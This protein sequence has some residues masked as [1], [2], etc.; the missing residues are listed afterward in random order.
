MSDSQLVGREPCPECGSKDNL[1]R[2]DDGHGFC[3]GQGCGYYD[4]GDS[5]G[6]ACAPQKTRVPMIDVD[7][8]ALPHRGI[9]EDTCR[10]FKYGIGEYRGQPVQVAQYAGAQ[11]LRGANKA[12]SWV[13]T[14]EGQLYG[15]SLWAPQKRLV[16]TEGEIDCLSYA[17]A[18]DSRW[19]VVSVPNGAGGAKRAIEKNVEFCESFDEV[20]FLFDMDKPGQAAAEECAA[21]LSP[22]KARIGILS[23]KDP[24]EVLLSTGGVKELYEVPFKAKPFR[25]E[26]IV[27]GTELLEAI[28]VKPEQGISY[29]WSCLDR[30]TYGQRMDEVV[31]WIAG[32][33][34]GKSQVLR[35]VAMN[36]WSAHGERVG[37]ISLEEANRTSAEGFVSLEMNKR[38]HLP[39][40]RSKVS[41]EEIAAAGGILEGFAFYDHFGS[42]AGEILLPKIRY[43]AVALGIRWFVLDHLSIMISGTAT[44]GD[45]RKRLDQLCTQLRSLASELNIGLHVVSHLRKA[46]G[47]PHE[48]GG[49][50]S[51][52]DIRSSGA[53]AQISN[54]VIALERDQQAKGREQNQTTIRVLKNRFSGDLGI[55]GVLEFN[56]ETGRMSE[57]T[58]SP[59]TADG[60]ND[61]V[62]Y[63]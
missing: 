2:F 16:I 42:V 18:T 58:W 21:I 30:L 41:D 6:T 7:Y 63:F 49:K 31:T 57:T 45:E 35:E 54:I 38:L 51:L 37:V 3:F 40:V 5:E 59:E 14:S 15:Q 13:G 55:A 27:E 53:V 9:S 26:G 4:H 12:F 22:G 34:T 60:D 39:D 61:N 46:G 33:G 10:K 43:M 20:V 50:I 25:P 8:V 32:T 36:L 28:I 48:E 23:K 52:Q 47:T 11:K 1:G 19:P 62:S 24:N 44:E 56:N 29:P 17:Q